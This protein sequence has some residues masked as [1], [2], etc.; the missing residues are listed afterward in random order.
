MEKVIIIKGSPGFLVTEEILKILMRYKYMMDLFK[1]KLRYSHT[2]KTNLQTVYK[3][4]LKG[5]LNKMM[6]QVKASIARVIVL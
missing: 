1:L 6:S 4:Q 2:P 5:Q 3:V